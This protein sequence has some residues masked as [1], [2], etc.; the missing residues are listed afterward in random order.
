MDTE[1]FKLK[2]KELREIAEKENFT[3]RSSIRKDKYYISLTYLGWDSFTPG[4]N[5]ARFVR[6]TTE[7][8]IREVFSDI[9]Q[10]Y[11]TSGGW[12]DETYRIIFG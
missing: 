5:Q 9:K 8:L 4:M 10:L 6:T 3:V 1:T 11:G 2:V 12:K 7:K